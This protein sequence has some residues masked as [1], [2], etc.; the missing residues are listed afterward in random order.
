MTVRKSMGS[1]SIETNLANKTKKRLTIAQHCGVFSSYQPDNLGRRHVQCGNLRQA[2]RFAAVYS[3]GQN[4]R[5]KP[6]KESDING[7]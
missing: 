5:G 2:G 3:V 1:D 7:Y 6:A 4:R